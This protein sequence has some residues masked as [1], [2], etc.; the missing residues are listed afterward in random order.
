MNRGGR[1][2]VVGA[3]GM[4][5]TDMVQAFGQAGH[6]VSAPDRAAFDLTDA[7][8]CQARVAGHEVVLNC[9]AW[10]DVDGAE[11]QEAQA[12]SINATGA[13]NLARACATQGAR[14]VQISTDYVFDGT[15][16]TPY[17]EDAPLTPVS[18][19]GRTKAAG[20]QAVRAKLADAYVVRTAWLYGAAG[21]NFV[22][23]MARLAAS[24]ESVSVVADQRG[25]PTWTGDVARAVCSLVESGAPPGT[26]HAT[27]AGTATWYDLAREV[28]A[29]IGLDP[30]RV[31]PTTTAAFPRPAP[32]PAY[33]VLGHRRWAAAGLSPIRHWQQALAEAL[34]S[35]LPRALPS[36]LPRDRPTAPAP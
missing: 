2:L 34:P 11:S 23:T 17:D 24:H 7:D 14:L 9:A 5:G 22:A 1:V 13:G 32:R 35:V 31:R 26:Y 29:G 4:L 20:E 15:A 25:Q 27:S 18:A 12:Y 19:Y 10:T 28:F 6:Q 30:G 8:A 16:S 33:S 21:G 3:G 36:A